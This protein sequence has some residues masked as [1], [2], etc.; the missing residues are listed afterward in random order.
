MGISDSVLQQF[1]LAAEI[2]DAYFLAPGLPSITFDLKP[3]ALDPNAQEVVLLVDG[4]Q[5][6]YAHGPQQTTS[7][8]WPQ[9]GSTSVTFTPAIQGRR[10]Q[11]QVDGPWSW[12]RLLDSAEIRRTNVAD[13]TRVVFNVGGRIAVFQMRAGSAINPFSSKAVR[14]FRC[15][16]S[17]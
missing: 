4:Q 3:I 17:L 15:P 7:L 9:G 5:L 16:N 14:R 12:F 13:Q 10:N 8:K 2:R 6:N 1:E 11:R